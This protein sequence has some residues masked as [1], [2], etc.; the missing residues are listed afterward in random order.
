MRKIIIAL[1]AIGGIFFIGQGVLASYGD[2]TTYLGELYNGDGGQALEAYLDFPEDITVDSSG[3]FYIADTSNHVIRKINTSGIIS[4]YAGTGAYG[5]TNGASTHAEFALPKGVALDGDGNL[6][7]ADSANNMIRKVDIY[8]VVSTLVG[9]DLNSPQG[10]AV[11]GEYLYVADTNNNALKKVDLDSGDLEVLTN[12]LNAPKKL[13]IDDTGTYIYVADSGSYKVKRVNRVTADITDI[14]GTG[15]EE[16]AEGVGGEAGFENVWGV[17]YFDNKLYISDGDGF[18]DKLRVIDLSTNETS[19]LALD[20]VMASINFPSGLVVYDGSIYVTNQGIGTVR[21]FDLTDPDDLNEDFAGSERFGYRNGEADEVLFGRPWDIVLSPDR[22]WLYL[23]ENNKIR[24]IDY[25]TKETTHVIG[26]SVDY[27]IE[28]VAESARFSN[29]TSLAIDSAGDNLYVTDRWNNRIRKIDLSTQT[30][31]LLAGGGLDNTTGDDENGYLEGVGESARFNHP[32]GITI[33]PDDRYLYVTDSGNNRVRRIEI[34]TGQTSLIAGSGEAGNQDGVESAAMFNKPFGITI[35]SSG[36]NLYIA[37][38]NN[39]TIRR[40]NLS[41]NSVTTIAGTGSAGYSDAIGTNSVFSYP[42]YIAIDSI[43]N[44]YVSEVGSHRI[45]II[46]ANTHITKLVAGSGERSYHNGSRT[47]AKFN[48]IKGLIVDRQSNVLLVADSYNDVI[49]QIDI[50]GAAPYTD[51]APTATSVNPKEVSPSWDK[52]DG[53]RVNI[54]GTNFRHGA[55]VTFAS[56]E[57]VITYVVSST[58]LVV[59]LPLS[60]MSPGWYDVSVSNIDGQ[61]AVLA[62]GIGIMNNDGQVPAV[63]YSVERSGSFYAYD[64]SLSGGYYITTGN[65]IGN[66]NEEIITGTGNGFGPQVRVFD[67]EGN[68]KSQFFAYYSFLRSGVRVASCDLDGDGRDEIVTA[69]GPGGRPHIRIFDAYGNPTVENGFFALDGQFLGGANIA[70]G[71]IDEDGLGEI[72]VAAGPG[73]GPHVTVHEADGSLIGNFMAYAPTFRGGIKIDTID[74]N[75]DGIME[76]ITGPEQGG[77]HVQIFTG[78]GHQIT[79][80]TFVFD[81]SF[82][83]GLSVAGGDVDGDGLDEML[84]TPGPES[85]AMLKVYEDYGD[86]YVNSFYLYSRDFKGAAN[87]ASGDINGDGVDEIVAIS[88]SNGPPYVVS[89]TGTG[90]LVGS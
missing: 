67:G 34:A 51:S 79:P 14:A 15:T 53:L 2:T 82:S 24:R 10:V 47:S 87:I 68:V 29:I 44:L 43:G 19:L 9:T 54:L 72:L 52:G 63:V 11:Y 48:N 84:I 65:V 70:C 66:G 90:A 25:G 16:Y 59:E 4:T 75:G 20:Q 27:Y 31:T 12:D 69:P 35:D 86:T 18:D 13:A 36:H 56:H 6:Y 40:I 22:E 45:R 50:T 81:P 28:G 37:D 17:A 39:H 83:G 88:A 55:T 76:V 8:G 3:N 57:A 58:E 46:E 38:E 1:S 60:V 74:L 7:I 62:S 26:S 21:K 32:G 73:G 78:K 5:S 41:S 61:T 64:S 23:A 89:Y 80:G 33:S 77:P 30:S 85:E 71:D 49:R 42:E